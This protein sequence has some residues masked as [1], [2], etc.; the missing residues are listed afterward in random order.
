METLQN[1]I[2]D[3]MPSD[4]VLFCDPTKKRAS[5]LEKYWLFD[6]HSLYR[7][8]LNRSKSRFRLSNLKIKCL[9]EWPSKK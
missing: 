8:S 4:L 5:I 3:F 2:R 6:G 9:C 7:V 1:I